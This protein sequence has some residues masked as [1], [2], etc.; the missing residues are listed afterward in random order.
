MKSVVGEG[1]GEAS[2]KT[3]SLSFSSTS[4]ATLVHKGSD[5]SKDPLSSRSSSSSK[6]SVA[7]A[8][9]KGKMTSS[10]SSSSFKTTSVQKD[11]G[12][13]KE[14][15]SHRP[16]LSL[17]GKPAV[18]VSVKGKLAS[19]SSSSTSKAK[20]AQNGRADFMEPISSRPSAS[21]TASVGLT[22]SKRKPLTVPRI[23]AKREFIYFYIGCK[24]V[25]HAFKFED[26]LSMVNM[27]PKEME[28]LRKEYAHIPQGVTSFAIAKLADFIA[29]QTPPLSSEVYVSMKRAGISILKGE[30][31]I[32]IGNKL[33]LCDL[34]DGIEGNFATFMRTKL[35]ESR[36]KGSFFSNIDPT[37][38]PP[39]LVCYLRNE[40]LGAK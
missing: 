34:F 32:V 33:R 7:Y 24:G 6:S 21:K 1:K 17:K 36:V 8:S 30:G 26:K 38:L 16:F 10:S 18:H 14:A 31:S 28:V 15:I 23:S 4:K 39:L 5:D 27:S 12:S 40:C 20:A 9:V 29:S 25:K 35:K 22:I 3:T 2:L 37:F 19:T 13:S 11:R